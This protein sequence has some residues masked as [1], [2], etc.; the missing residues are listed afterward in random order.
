MDKY[1]QKA[2]QKI[3]YKIYEI[4]HILFGKTA[5]YSIL[6]NKQKASLHFF[7]VKKRK[8]KQAFFIFC[9]ITYVKLML[10][11]NTHIFNRLNIIV[12]RKIKHY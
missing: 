2:G 10:N 4:C 8:D 1:I 3:R 12:F 11:I 9:C 6:K 5:K 7:N